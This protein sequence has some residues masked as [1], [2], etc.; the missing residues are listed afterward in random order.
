MRHL[1]ALALLVILSVTILSNCV[2]SRVQE[3]SGRV[4]KVTDGDTITLLDSN[5]SELPVRLMGIDA[6]ERHQAFSQTSRENLAN[7][8]FGKW[9]IVQFRKHDRYGRIVGKVILDG[10]D[11]CLEQIKAGMAWHYKAFQREQSVEDRLAYAAAETEARASRRGLW[12][13]ADPKP[14]WQFRRDDNG[15]SKD[16]EQNDLSLEIKSTFSNVLP[17]Q[18]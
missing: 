13:D 18:L 17:P 11:E 3:I 14:P 16:V 15:S 4:V 10:Q 2:G 7:Q 1:N 8:I 5:N 6:P 9:I 12:Q